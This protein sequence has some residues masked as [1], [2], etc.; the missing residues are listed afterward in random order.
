[1]L[2]LVATL[3]A[4]GGAG[5][6][7]VSA[8]EPTWTFNAVESSGPSPAD[9]TL[10]FYPGSSFTQTC[11]AYCPSPGSSISVTYAAWGLTGTGELYGAYQVVWLALGALGLFVALVVGLAA[12]PSRRQQYHHRTLLWGMRLAGLLPLVA[13]ALLIAVQPGTIAADSAGAT[14]VHWAGGSPSPS[15]SFSGSCAAGAQGPDGSCPAGETQTWGPGIGLYLSLVAGFVVLVG[16]VFLSLARRALR[17]PRGP[18]AGPVSLTGGT[19]GTR[20]PGLEASGLGSLRPPPAGFDRPPM[21]G[22]APG[23]CPRC[24]AF[25]PSPAAY[26]RICG[27]RLPPP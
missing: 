15:Q 2:F 16:S 13:L 1:M 8:F 11:E 23:A 12:R 17:D 25:T 19:P 9:Q 4:V 10:A 22:L 26:C 24:G 27:E 6:L 3:L 21:P 5:L 7:V 18:P 20:V 14:S